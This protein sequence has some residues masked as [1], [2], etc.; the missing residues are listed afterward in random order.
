MKNSLYT[1]ASANMKIIFGGKFL[2][3]LLTSFLLTAYFMWNSVWM[4]ELPN[5]EMIYG[6]LFFPSLLLVFYPAAF[7]IQ[8][9]ADNLNLEILF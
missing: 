1:A 8:N 7:G 6:H 9:D 5:D 2:W 4:G 3:F